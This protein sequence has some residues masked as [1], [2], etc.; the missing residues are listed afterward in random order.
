MISACRQDTLGEILFEVPYAPIEF[1]ILAGEPGFETQVVPRSSQPTG[2]VDAMQNAQVE[3]NDIN[4]FGGLRA[5][6]V[7]IT[8]EDF[9]EISR[10]EVRACPVGTP[11]G[12]DI[13]TIVFSQGD[14][15]GRRLQSV[16]LSPSLL[17]FKTLFVG[18]DNVRVELVFILGQSTTRSLEGRL[19]WGMAAFG[20]E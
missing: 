8:G 17:N 20:E 10:M 2:I 4:V 14:L 19:E 15:F 12:C 13:G 7:S 9:R 16:D 11:G 6:V 1:A 18:N 3:A 5:R